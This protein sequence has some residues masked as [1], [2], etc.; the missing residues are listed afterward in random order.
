MDV[1]I[2]ALGVEVVGVVDSAAVE[3]TLADESMLRCEDER[4]RKEQCRHQNDRSARRDT[5]VE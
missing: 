1:Q 4:D 5:Q 3:D 2:L